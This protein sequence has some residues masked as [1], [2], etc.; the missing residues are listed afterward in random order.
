MKL[1]KE[2]Q[3]LQT[4]NV[5]LKNKV[6]LLENIVQKQS[7][8][9]CTVKNNITKLKQRTM[10]DNVIIAGIKEHPNENCKR[11]VENFLEN[12]L[13][14]IITDGGVQAAYQI[15]STIQRMINGK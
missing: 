11:S 2:V 6:D 13:G 15:G 7:Q 1:I 9:V 5:L 12:T 10:Q 8:Q 14:I 3:Q 4:E